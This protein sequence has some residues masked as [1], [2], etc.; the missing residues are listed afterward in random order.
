MLENK[1][2]KLDACQ[3]DT[4][5]SALASS[6]AIELTHL[7]QTSAQELDTLIDGN[8]VPRAVVKQAARPVVLYATVKLL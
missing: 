2:V 7:M 1:G 6:P 5:L 4:C 3:L 8:M